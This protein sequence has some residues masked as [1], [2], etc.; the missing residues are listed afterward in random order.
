MSGAVS[1]LLVGQGVKQAAWVYCMC[2]KCTLMRDLAERKLKAI[3]RCRNEPVTAYAH[4]SHQKPD[5][6]I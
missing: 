4:E 6:E 3:R 1:F 2:A 5:E